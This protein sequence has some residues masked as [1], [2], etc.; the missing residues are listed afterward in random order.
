MF[1]IPMALLLLE[2]KGPDFFRVG[3]FP[4]IIKDWQGD[5]KK[6]QHRKQNTFTKLKYQAHLYLQ[7]LPYYSGEKNAGFAL[8]LLL[9]S[10]GK[11]HLHK[12][13]PLDS[14]TLPSSSYN[15]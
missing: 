14:N 6:S 4:G 7:V 1:S 10:F 5:K 2:L 13:L 15:N 11:I 12:A 3:L 8:I 9:Y